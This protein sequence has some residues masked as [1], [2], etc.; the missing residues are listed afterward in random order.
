MG[1]FEKQINVQCGIGI[2]QPTGPL[3][4]TADKATSKNLKFPFLENNSV[5]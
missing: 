4:K 1:V 5:Q 2:M 3:Q